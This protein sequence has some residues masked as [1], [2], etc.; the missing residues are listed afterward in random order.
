MITEPDFHQNLLKTRRTSPTF[1]IW[2]K[3]L[4]S[5]LSNNARVPKI[6]GTVV[7]SPFSMIVYVYSRSD[8]RA[9][10][11]MKKRFGIGFEF[12]HTTRTTRVMKI[13]IEKKI[14][15]LNKWTCKNHLLLQIQAIA[16]C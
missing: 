6:L 3:H 12:S 9:S 1:F 2:I 8:A 13:Q 15:Q 14:T 16:S 4:E 10:E 11:L 7:P 5:L